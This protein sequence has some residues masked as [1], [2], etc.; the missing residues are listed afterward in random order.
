MAA[1]K[2]AAKKTTA[3]KS[4]ATG[5]DEREEQVPLRRGCG[6]MAAHML[7]L[8]KHPTFRARQF[9]LEQDTQKQRAVARDVADTYR[10]GAAA[11][12]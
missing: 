12:Y 6:A 2:G 7:L 4:A 10:V 9:R 8:E 1:K 5:G 11:G 3:R